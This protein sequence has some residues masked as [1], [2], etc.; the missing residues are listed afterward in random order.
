VAM[1][2]V[3]LVHMAKISKKPLFTCGLGGFIAVY[4]LAVQGNRF[5]ILNGEI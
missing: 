5:H 3:T 4:S 1:L 2:A